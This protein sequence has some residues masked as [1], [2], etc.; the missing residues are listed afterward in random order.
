MLFQ[1]DGSVGVPYNICKKGQKY[2][3]SNCESI[4]LWNKDR[5]NFISLFNVT[6]LNNYTHNSDSIRDKTVRVVA[7]NMLPYIT[8]SNYSQTLGGF[9]GEVWQMIEST[10]GFTSRVS[11]IYYDTGL[12]IITS[13]RADVMLAAVVSKRGLLNVKYSQPYFY[14]WYEV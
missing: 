13:G 2:V 9:L 11:S 12:E 4:F 6:L 3:K 5:S 8:S 10:L 14:N 7:D 1:I